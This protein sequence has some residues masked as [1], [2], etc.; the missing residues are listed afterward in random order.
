MVGTAAAANSAG[1]E[2]MKQLTT[3]QQANLLQFMTRAFAEYLLPT[4]IP[5]KKTVLL[6]QVLA[7]SC[8]CLGDE[9]RESF[10]LA[11][12]QFWGV[13]GLKTFDNAVAKILCEEAP[14]SG[15]GD[16]LSELE[17]EALMMGDLQ[18]KQ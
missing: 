16:T 9:I 3:Q 6:E 1:R 14:A 11:V 15:V 2:R 13:G 10:R 4:E 17:L 18:H 5:S 8:A 12:S 7:I